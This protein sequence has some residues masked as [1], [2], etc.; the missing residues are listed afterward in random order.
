MF[1]CELVFQNLKVVIQNYEAKMHAKHIA[2]MKMM[3]LLFPNIDYY[4]DVLEVLNHKGEICIPGLVSVS[5]PF[6]C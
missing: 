3:Q 5:I 4:A 2:A 6:S 1:Q